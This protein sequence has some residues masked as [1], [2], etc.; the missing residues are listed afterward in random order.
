M[1][2]TPPLPIDEY[3]RDRRILRVDGILEDT[4]SDERRLRNL[5]QQEFGLDC[6]DDAKLFVDVSTG[7]PYGLVKFKRR[8][9]A[10]KA[11][12]RS[13]FTPISG[14]LLRLTVATLNDDPRILARE[15]AL[16]Y[17]DEFRRRQQTAQPVLFDTCH[18]NNRYSP[19]VYDDPSMHT[20][21]FSTPVYTPDASFAEYEDWRQSGYRRTFEATPASS[22]PR[23]HCV[24]PSMQPLRSFE[25]SPLIHAKPAPLLSPP[26]SSLPSSVCS[27]HTSMNSST[28]AGGHRSSGGYSV[29][30]T[31]RTMDQTSP[32]EPVPLG[33][34]APYSYYPSNPSSMTTSR[35]VSRAASR[36]GSLTSSR[37]ES[38]TRSPQAGLSRS[39][40]Q[41]ESLVLPPSAVVTPP[42]RRASEEG[43]GEVTQAMDDAS[44]ERTPAT[45]QSTWFRHDPYRRF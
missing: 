28:M 3:N 31:D 14:F 5:V 29:Q 34:R 39:S 1:S 43:A 23:S 12:G 8:K 2:A 16:E 32:P 19:P 25:A 21:G 40:V 45:D 36:G 11:L 44:T 35:I 33:G 17:Q 13:D 42:P 26:N 27:P 22:G 4:I 37:R 9:V 41:P 20:P 10:D 18:W 38:P 15:Q 30:H 24:S 7:R 6:L